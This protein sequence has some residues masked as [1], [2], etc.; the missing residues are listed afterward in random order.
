M[1]DGKLWL[2]TYRGWRTVTVYLIRA[3]TENQAQE[4]AAK[5]HDEREPYVYPVEWVGENVGVVWQDES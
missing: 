2:Y 5:I 1:Q 4:L 3:S